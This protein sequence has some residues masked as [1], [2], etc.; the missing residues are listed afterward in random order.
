MN[1]VR[2][3]ASVRVHD[4]A[5]GFLVEF[6]PEQGGGYAFSYLP[7]YDGSPVSLTM[8]VREE[9]YRFD[10]FPPIFD[11]L[12]PEGWQLEAL[13]RRA[14]LDRHDYMGQL[15]AVGQDVV[16]AVTVEPAPAEEMPS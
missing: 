1:S 10:R 13:L 5:A 11:G 3:K 15:L 14:K 9:P 12:L 2:R 6:G 4:R 7:G 8:P 16:G